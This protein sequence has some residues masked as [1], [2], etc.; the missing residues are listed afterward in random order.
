VG[1]DD[2]IDDGDHDPLMGYCSSRIVQLSP[3]SND[4]AYKPNEM[5]DTIALNHADVPTP[6]APRCVPPPETV[7]VDP[8]TTLTFRNGSTTRITWL[9]LS[10]T[11]VLLNDST[12]IPDKRSKVAHAPT[13]SPAALPPYV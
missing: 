1:H 11:N 5:P 3:T 10:T 4:P 12:T 7:A 6:S 8:A 2:G 9:P 13:T